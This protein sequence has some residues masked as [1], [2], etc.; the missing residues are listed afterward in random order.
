[1]V[2]E[3]KEYYSNN[4][5]N[6]INPIKFFGLIGVA[7]LIVA[8]LAPIRKPKLFSTPQFDVIPVILI[9]VII[10][11]LYEKYNLKL[12]FDD[13]RKKLIIEYRRIITGQK[14]ISIDYSKIDSILVKNKYNS[15]VKIELTIL[16]SSNEKFNIHEKDGD[17]DKITIEHIHNHIQKIK[18]NI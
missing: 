9:L 8:F 6:R 5:D 15:K 7:S 2:D 18:S 10:Y 1:M 16:N 13:T 17:F 3:N 11:F 14:L 4:C 12:K